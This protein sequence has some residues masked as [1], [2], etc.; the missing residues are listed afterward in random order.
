MCLL[1]P[2][3]H[4]HCRCTTY[5]VLLCPHLPNPCPSCPPTQVP[6]L[7]TQPANHPSFIPESLSF[8]PESLSKCPEFRCA[9]DRFHPLPCQRHWTQTPWK[10]QKWMMF[11]N[12]RIGGAYRDDEVSIEEGQG[13]PSRQSTPE[14]GLSITESDE[15]LGEQYPPE[16]S[17]NTEDEELTSLSKAKRRRRRDT[18]AAAEAEMLKI[19]DRRK[20]AQEKTP[21]FP[22]GWFCGEYWAMM[23]I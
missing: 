13:G 4:T 12:G 2:L 18:K 14:D 16:F 7:F 19:R 3:I 1:N 22:I 5:D 10:L 11:G 15:T 9:P 6:K 17:E 23:K 8:I 21:W 20:A